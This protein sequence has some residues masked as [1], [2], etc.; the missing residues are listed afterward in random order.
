M[1]R[2]L[3]SGGAGFIGSHLCARLLKEGHSV[4]CLDDLSTGRKQNITPF[5]QHP[6][7]DFL[8]H[9]VVQP[10]N[11]VNLDEVYNLASPA[12]P[13][14]FQKIPLKT[15]HINILGVV[16]TLDI[17]RRN[18]AKYLQTSTSEVYG[19]PIEHPQKETY[20]GNVNPIGPRACY[21]ESKRVAET[22]IVEYR[23]KYQ[24]QTHIAR[25]FNTY[26]PRMDPHDGRVV[27]NFIYQALKG[28]DLTVYGQ[29]L[30][31]RSFCFIDD[32]VEGLIKLM[33][34]E[35]SEPVNLGNPDNYQ[36]IDLA[37]KVLAIC[38]SSSKITYHPLPE[39][40]P[41]RRQPDISRARDILD[42]HPKISLDQGL[43][44]TVKYFQK[45]ISK[46]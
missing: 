15:I 30:Q 25:V 3:I 41:T 12:S 32:L 21:D 14:K 5:I 45:L 17:A 37:K 2:I 9:D 1:K 40:D 46:E 26:G 19:D 33:A 39:D 13:P 44:K 35:Y 24:I 23:R 18:E 31:T 43:M 16:N 10:I 28:D 6:H 27:S 34:A 42:W 20:W 38:Q 4:L 7:F 22:I 8:E 36:V 29:G 11:L